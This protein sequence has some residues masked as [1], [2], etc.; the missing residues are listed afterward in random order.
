MDANQIIDK[1]MEYYDVTTISELSEILNI[2]QPAISKWKKNNSVN[3]IK[4]KCRELGIYDVIFGDINTQNIPNESEEVETD[5]STMSLLKEAYIKAIENDDLKGL[6]VYL[7]DYNCKKNK[8]KIENIKFKIANLPHI[9]GDKIS[10]LIYCLQNN[11]ALNK[12]QLINEIK[13]IKQNLFKT[14]PA[15]IFAKKGDLNRYLLNEKV[16]NHTA[17]IIDNFITKDEI[18]HIFKKRSEII[19]F[20]IDLAKDYIL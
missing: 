5:E 13:N 11:H 17:L 10:I 7:M 8:I 14:I 9:S 4:K 12:E 2:G 20:L 3:T 16:L 19:E 1:L 6:R 15:S 18:E